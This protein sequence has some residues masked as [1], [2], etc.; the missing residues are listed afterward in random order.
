MTI[1]QMIA[2][3]VA[4]ADHLRD[5]FGQDRSLLLGHSWGSFLGIQVAAAAPERFHAYIGVGQV[6]W[7]L[8]SEVMA[9]EYLLDRYRAQGDRAMVRKIEAAPASLSDGLSKAWLR[10]RDT[11]MH[12]LR[13]GTTRDMTSVITGVFLP[14]WQC[15][16]Y[17]LQDKVAIWRG[18]AFSR[19]HLWDDFIATDLTALVDTLDLPV[20]FF[21]GQ[22]DFTANHTLARQFFDGISA[23]GKGFY[24]FENSA[25]G[26]VFEEPQRAREILGQ[27]VLAGVNHLADGQRA[28]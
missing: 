11:A 18:L 10:L 2:D 24:T 12:G 4:V 26:P 25:H 15:R 20:Y 22:N 23:P 8:R 16:A 27:D 6:S 9:R 5:R 28:P 3:T 17:T 14:V 19:R 1:A 21:L 7:Q 13:V